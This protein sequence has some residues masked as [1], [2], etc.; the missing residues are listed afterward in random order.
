MASPCRA[1]HVGSLLRPAYLRDARQGVR[2]G[3][4]SDAE[5]RALE[6]RAVRE[7]ITLQEAIGLDVITDGELRRTTWIATADPLSDRA[8]L[9]GYTNLPEDDAWR[10]ATMWRS[11][12]GAPAAV[13]TTRRSFF[14]ERLSVRRDLVGAEYPFLKA[15]A[16]GRTKYTIPAPSWHRVYWHPVHSRDAYPT[17]EE[18]LGDVRDYVRGEV[19]R[20]IAQGCDYIQLDA[21]NY[22]SFHCDPDIRAVL[23]SQGR[24]LDAELLTDA[25]IDNSVFEGIGGV[26]RAM[27]ICRGNN[28]GNW[29]ANGGYGQIADTL[30][31]QL[32]NIDRLLLEYDTPRAGD[33]GPLRHV[34][35]DAEVVLGLL[36]TKEGR[37]EDAAVVQARIREAAGYV[38]L[39]RLAL[40][41][42]CGF[43]SVETGNPLT[44]EEQEAKLQL[45]SQVAREVWQN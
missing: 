7:A 1:D 8:P 2:E 4:V 35:P 10:W 32:S 42:Q 41:P 33:F 18:F 28:A 24:N 16:H 22:A 43:A 34:R 23:T 15:H 31:P 40:S 45:V 3:R 6:D 12:E 9:T 36:T 38:P 30:F 25:E 19:N 39:E 11:G 26:T 21:P 20:A 17:V 13:G 5:L 14:T 29:L 37:L 27:H 44:P